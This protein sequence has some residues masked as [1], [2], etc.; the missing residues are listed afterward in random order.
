MGDNGDS[1]VS[2]RPVLLEKILKC[3]VDKDPYKTL[4]GAKHRRDFNLRTIEY[5]TY[6]KDGHLD[7]PTHCDEDS[8]LTLGVMLSN[9]ETD[10]TGGMFKTLEVD[11]TFKEYSVKQGDA[12][13]WLSHKYHSVSP[14]LS[15]VRKTFVVELWLE[16]ENFSSR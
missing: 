12:L 7:D 16:E 11:G 15:G 1:F 8:V 10:F 9:P 6:I 13:L 3:M 5:H 4:V 14:V 2:L